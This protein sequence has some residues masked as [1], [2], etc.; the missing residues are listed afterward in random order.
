MTAL[1]LV[2]PVLHPRPY[3]TY[4]YGVRCAEDEWSRIG[5]AGSERGAIRAAVMHLFDRTYHSAVVYDIDSVVVARI[6]RDRNTI[7]IIS[8]LFKE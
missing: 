1:K 7:K 4:Y 6:M 5:R 3:S 8:V 2:S